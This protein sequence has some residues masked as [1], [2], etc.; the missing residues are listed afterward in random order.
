MSDFVV[1]RGRSAVLLC[2]ELTSLHVRPPTGDQAAFPADSRRRVDALGVADLTTA[3]VRGLH[4]GG[5]PVPGESTGND[6]AADEIVGWLGKRHDLAPHRRTTL[7][8]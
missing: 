7:G 1:A 6:L 3:S 4:L 5:A 8:A 2:L